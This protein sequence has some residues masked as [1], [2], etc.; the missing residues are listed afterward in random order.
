VATVLIDHMFGVEY[1]AA[2][3]SA[4]ARDI[5][6][7][8][9]TTFKEIFLAILFSEEFLLNMERPKWF[10]ESYFNTAERVYWR[11]YREFFRDLNRTT[12]NGGNIGGA[13]LSLMY[14]PAFSLK[15]GRWPFVA[16]DVLATSYQHNGLRSTLLTRSNAKLPTDETY[17]PEVT[18]S[19]GWGPE[20]T[21]TASTMS[22]P[23][24][25]N[26]MFIS[27]A[28]RAATATELST[29]TQVITT[30]RTATTSSSADCTLTNPP[31][32]CLRYASS[33]NVNNRAIVVMDYLSRL[34]ESYF[35]N[36]VN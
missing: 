24:F 6:A 10:E 9:P 20:L 15:L 35:H 16:S 36:A 28:G 11:P 7:A 32:G 29:L 2:K 26:Y 1:D 22:L 18:P 30:A 25:I 13:T 14:Q 5:A 33:T 12:A 8:G 19:Q 23:E 21:E 3:R 34:P 4:L 17:D 27:V 31:S